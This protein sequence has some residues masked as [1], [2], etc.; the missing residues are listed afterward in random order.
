MHDEEWRRKP[1][2]AREAGADAPRD[3]RNSPTTR[4]EH[5]VAEPARLRK[6]PEGEPGAGQRRADPS[7]LELQEPRNAGAGHT[8]GPSVLDGSRMDGHSHI[9]ADAADATTDA[10]AFQW[11]QHQL[12]IQIAAATDRQH[13]ADTGRTERTVVAY[14]VPL[15]SPSPIANFRKPPP[16]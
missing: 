5:G 7:Q 10:A 6:Q 8:T 9:P 14:W 12:A 11:V 16:L 1:P 4:I 15:T 3:R 2:G 13:T